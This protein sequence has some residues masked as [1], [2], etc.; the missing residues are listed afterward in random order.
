MIDGQIR[1]FGETQAGN[2]VRALNALSKQGLKSVSRGRLIA[3]C[4]V[5]ARVF[6]DD[7]GGEMYY[8]YNTTPGAQTGFLPGETDK[9]QYP[10]HA[11]AFY[12]GK[13]YDELHPR[14]ISVG[15]W[16]AAYCEQNRFSTDDMMVHV[17]LGPKPRIRPNTPVVT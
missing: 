8:L 11:M 14:G 6:I 2:N 12:G 10:Y 17:Y 5:W 16:I 7:V 3:D 9:V 13:L 1:R 4:S 15:D